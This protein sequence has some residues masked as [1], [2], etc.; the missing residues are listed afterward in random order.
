MTVNLSQHSAL[1]YDKSAG[2]YSSLGS[3]G[4]AYLK[5]LLCDVLAG[6]KI[7]VVPPKTH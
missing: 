3:P 7:N 5:H 4:K 1:L 2:F 6:I